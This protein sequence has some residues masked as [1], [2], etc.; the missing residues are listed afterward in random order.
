MAD[1]DTLLSYPELMAKL[2]QLCSTNATG[3][4]FITTEDN[5]PIRFV[6]KEGTIVS[7]AVKRNRGMTALEEI[8]NTPKGRAK[9]GKDSIF[10]ADGEQELPPTPKLL[11][12]LSGQGFSQSASVGAKGTQ[13]TLSQ[14]RD[15]VQFELT[16]VVGPMASMICD[17][18][19]ETFENKEG[20]DVMGLLHDIS[21]EIENKAESDAFLQ[22]VISKLKG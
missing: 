11:E 9:F 1:T 10:W 5:L 21:Q 19:F 18:Q 22:K 20:S 16:E 7:M 6:L 3:T 8:K 17:E 14:V 12:M 4:L 13:V 15:I 2:R